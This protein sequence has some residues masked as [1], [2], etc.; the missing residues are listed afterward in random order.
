MTQIH[1]RFTTEQIQLLFKQYQTGDM[2]RLEIQEILDIGKTRFFRLFGDYK[3]LAE[4]FQINYQ[5]KSKPR[6]SPD[7]EKRIIL[8]LQREKELIDDP[9]IPITS[10]NYTAMRDRLQKQNI[11]VSVPTIIDRARQINCY[12][13]QRKH[14]T[15]TREVLTT[16]IGALI[17]HDSSIHLWSPYASE[18]WTLITSI[19]DYSR[20]LLF[21]DLFP[22]ETTWEHIQAAQSLM[23]TYGLPLQYYVD[24]L[25]VFRFV[26]GRDSVWRKNVLETDDVITQWRQVLAALKVDVSYALSPQA[27]GKVERPYR[28]LQDRVVRTCAMERLSSLEDV[29]GVL[30]DEVERYN[31][32]QV[33]STTGEI[34]RIRFDQAKW[35]GNSLFRPF[36]VPK[37]YS[38]T[39]DVFCLRTSRM[40]DGYRRISLFSESIEVPNVPLREYVEIH[41]IP[42]PSKNVVKI[43]IWH[44]QK[45]VKRLN[46]PFPKKWVHF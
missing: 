43:R 36:S 46:I 25:R 2:T 16:A 44:H 27:K 38:S 34:P 26:Q 33:H 28:W 37:P 8:E 7:I 20:M 4:E 30:H 41:M 31:N 15:H 17:Q 11:Q 22:V 35:K 6:I 24:N 29:R 1:K 14:K 21:A 45:L 12:I 42:D 19:D 10:Y 32:H 39:E 18:K 23:L 13:P 9:R 5:R 40:V 3:K